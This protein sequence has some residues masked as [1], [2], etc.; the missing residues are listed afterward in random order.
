MD[1]MILHSRSLSVVCS[2]L[3]KLDISLQP[4]I[5]AKGVSH[6]SAPGAPILTAFVAEGC[7]CVNADEAG[8]I[9]L[10][11]RSGPKM[12]VFM[13]GSWQ[14]VTDSEFV[15]ITFACRNLRKL[16]VSSTDVT[17]MG[18]IHAISK[19]WLGELK[20]LDMSRCNITDLGMTAL[21]TP[22]APALRSVD[23]T[24]CASITDLGIGS[25]SRH[26][27]CRIKALLVTDTEITEAGL[28]SVVATCKKGL[29][30]LEVGDLDISA[31]AIESLFELCPQLT[32]INAMRHTMSPGALGVLAYP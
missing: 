25:L 14:G 6:L 23:L 18:L 26:P 12:E 17:D 21:S 20:S 28:A 4:F 15:G 30:K 9:G 24:G 10:A 31:E 11:Q 29:K 5:T 22:E 16:S 13:I 2:S 19:G 1:S 3:Q 7:T 8:V 32:E 27:R